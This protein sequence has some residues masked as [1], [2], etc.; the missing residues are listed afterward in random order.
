VSDKEWNQV[1]ARLSKSY[2]AFLASSL[3]YIGLP[4][5]RGDVE[6]F[7]KI[8]SRGKSPIS[9]LFSRKLLLGRKQEHPT[10]VL[11]QGFDGLSNP[12][13]QCSH[14]PFARMR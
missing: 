12:S 13:V 11:L 5:E 9:S 4:T 8:T 7:T 1:R 10:R 6:L 3:I 2:Q 14:I